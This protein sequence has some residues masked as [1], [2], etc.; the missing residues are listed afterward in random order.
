MI[1]RYVIYALALLAVTLLSVVL[2]QLPA[3]GDSSGP[4]GLKF[5]HKSHV[6]DREIACQ[7]CHTT[8]SASLSLAENLIGTHESCTAC[9]EDQLGNDCAYCHT[10]PDNI[11]PVRVRERELKFSHKRHLDGGTTACQACH[12]FGEGDMTPSLPAMATC[13]SCHGEKNVSVACESCH[14]DF[15]SLLPQDHRRID[16]GR[17]HK[18]LTRLGSFEV[19]CA[20]CHAQSFCQDCH[21]GIELQGF[22]TKTAL[23]ADPSPKGSGKDSPRQLRLQQV[24]SLN[25]RFTHGVDAKAKK[26]DC[27]TCHEQ[28]AFC[29]QCHQSGD[30]AG[31]PKIKPASH[32]MAGFVTIGRGSGGG[33][34]ADE[35][36]K[37]LEACMSCHDVQGAD[38]TCMLCHTDAGTIR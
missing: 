36:R 28:Q 6:T 21:T 31:E 30:N 22:G 35:A 2:R 8:V 26:S 13:T 10:A 14:R 27:S 17:E 19:S 16:F 23:M 9:H 5:S 3:R 34:H 24:H 15:A 18:E 25:Y 11:Q 1:R 29:A 4:R 7:D 12:R 38:P 32:V 20:T 37:D 33:R